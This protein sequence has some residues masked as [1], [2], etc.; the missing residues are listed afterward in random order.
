MTH[1]TYILILCIIVYVMMASVSIA[2]IV[3]L[4]KMSLKLIRHGAEDEQIIK[5]KQ[6]TRKK[7]GNFFDM[8]ISALFCVVFACAF[9]FSAYVNVSGNAYF[10]DIPT[11]KVVNSPSMSKKHEKNEYLFK[12]NLNDQ[13][14]TFDV[15]LTYKIPDEFDLKLYDVVVYEMEDIL[16][17]HRIVEIEEPNAQHPNE[18][19]FRTQGDNVETADRFPVHYSQMRAIY[20]GEKIPFVGS[21]INF[22]Q[23]PAGW[24]C[25]IL[26]LAAT[27]ATPIIDKKLEKARAERYAVLCKQRQKL[28]GQAQ[29]QP[30]VAAPVCLYPVY[31]DSAKVAFSAPPTPNENKGERK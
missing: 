14:D 11:L 30:I 6:K 10:D 9:L 29:H 31:Y 25:M 7:N 17:I 5:E 2:V 4:T 3:A 1:E 15:V 8:L 23:S 19:Y 21:F 27:I 18:R 12:N 28:A 26:M 16:V 22:M 20:R 13:F 24:L